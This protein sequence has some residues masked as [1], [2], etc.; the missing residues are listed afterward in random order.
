MMIKGIAEEIG[1][2]PSTV[3]RAV[4][5]KWAR[6]PHGVLE[7]R[8][9]FSEEVQGPSGSAIPLLMVKRRVK[10]MIEEDSAHPLTDEQITAHLRVEGIEV[11]RRMVAKYREEMNIPP[12]DQ[13]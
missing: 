12:A 11:T 3:S 2:H 9:F 10:K 8:H 7:L 4:A 6:T 5:N 13:R 1:E